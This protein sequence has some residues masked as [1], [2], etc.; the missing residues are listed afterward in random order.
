[1]PRPS[2]WF[3]AITN[4]RGVAAAQQGPS[5]GS[6]PLRL[7]R[8]DSFDPVRW[9]DVLA[10]SGCTSCNVLFGDAHHHQLFVY[11]AQRQ[12]TWELP[13]ADRLIGGPS[14]C[15]VA[16]GAVGAEWPKERRGRELLQMIDFEEVE[17]EQ[18]IA[19][20]WEVLM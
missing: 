19:S 7:L 4:R 8:E 12:Q 14:V 9:T 18:L 11:C 17:R 1:M 5:R 6:L 10:A 20:L 13:C 16:N 15:S 2:G 3:V